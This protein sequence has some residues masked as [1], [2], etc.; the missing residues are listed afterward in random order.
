MSYLKTLFIALVSI[1]MIVGVASAAEQYVTVAEIYVSPDGTP[2][3]DGSEANPLDI[4]TA[5]GNNSPVRPGDTI[6]FK[7]G[8]YEGEMEGITRIPFGFKVSGA[9]DAPIIV[10]PASDEHVHLNGTVS[11]GSNYMHVYNLDIGDLKWDRFQEEHKNS[12]AFN[13]ANGGVG[14]KV[15]NCNIFGGSMGSGIWKPAINFEMYGCVI[16]DYGT[17]S[18]EGGRGHGHAVYTQNEEGTKHFEN[19]AFYRGCGWNFNIYTQGGFVRGYDVINNISF[20]GGWYMPE[21]V[22]FSYGLSGYQSAERIRFIR[23]VAYQPRYGQQ[24]RGNMR[25][26]PHRDPTVIHK[27]AEVRDNYIMGAYRGLSFGKFQDVVTTGNTIWSHGILAEISTAPGGSGFNAPDEPKPDL[28]NYEWHNNVYYDNGNETPFRHGGGVE[29]GPENEFLTFEEW[30][31][32]GLDVNSEMRPGRDGKPTGT[33]IFVNPNS[34]EQ[35]RAHIAVYNWDGKETVDVDLSEVLEEG[36]KY[37]VYN[38]LDIWQT[39]EMADPVVEGEF[40]GKDVTLPMKGDEASPDF[41]AFL[42]L[43]V[44]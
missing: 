43:P 2:A 41:D 5:V 28:D 42:V 30:Q 40:D 39:I 3:G 22:S 16:H 34:Y 12:T 24:W 7:G 8:T 20:A 9:E 36:Q 21:Q 15:I 37:R 35:G 25:L 32:L 11:F 38:L 31:A 17:M 29:N 18:R 44:H 33:A 23:N 6:L 1:C 13:I 27:D 14:S 19:N 10:K 26:I 4:H